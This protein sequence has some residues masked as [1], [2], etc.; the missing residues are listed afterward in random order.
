[1]DPDNSTKRIVC[2]GECMVELSERADGLITRAFG[3]DPLNTA[4]YLARMDVR[5]DYATA[6]GTDTF[7]D[8]MVEAWRAEGIGTRLTLR[9]PG[10]LPGLYLIRTDP[11]GERSFFHW[12]DSAPV[13]D[14]FDN[15]LK[16]TR[17]AVQRAL[18]RSHHI[19]TAQACQAGE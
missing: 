13:R 16:R 17:P 18:G 12:R 2:V 14:L 4:L 11:A 5:V 19:G 10:R 8:E 3:G 7:S 15:G 1:M 6:L 9:I